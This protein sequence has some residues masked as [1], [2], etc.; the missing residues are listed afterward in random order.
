MGL[1]F[2]KS[3]SPMSRAFTLDNSGFF[4]SSVGSAFVDRLNAFGREIKADGLVQFR[5]ED[6]LFL[7]IWALLSFTCWVELGSTNTVRIASGRV[8]AFIGNWT[9]FCHKFLYA[10]IGI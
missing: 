6:S 5:D 10:T 3:K 4:E 9:C 7:H 2:G 8:H 1:I